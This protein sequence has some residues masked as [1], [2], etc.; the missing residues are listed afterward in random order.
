MMLPEEKERKMLRTLRDTFAALGP[1]ER[2]V[3][4]IAVRAMAAG[5]VPRVDTLSRELGLPIDAIHETLASLEACDCVVMDGNR[6]RVAYP[7]TSDPMPYEV[8][9]SRG[10]A[11]ANCAID[12]LGAGAVL[13]EEVEIRSSC[14]F[15]GSPIRLRG[16]ESFKSTPTRPVVFVPQSDFRRGHA[17]ECVCPSINFYCNE[18]HG[19]AHTGALAARGRL[20]SL[21][22]ATG[23]GIA[24]FGNLLSP[25][26][27]RSGN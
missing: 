6:V 26:S 15:C 9:S 10:T 23:L 19:H 12:A 18:E 27:P 2:N 7:F 21:E 5:R 4:R 3:Q 8:V 25:T 14:S 16:L 1:K 22:E 17:S 11:Y 24:A 13:G 20:L